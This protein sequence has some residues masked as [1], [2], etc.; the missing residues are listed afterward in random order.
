M[1]TETHGPDL[2]INE[3]TFSLA[4]QWIL[5]IWQQVKIAIQDHMAKYRLDLVAQDIYEF[6][7]NQYCDWYLEFS[8]PILMGKL[9]E[10]KQL[11]GTRYTLLHILGELLRVVHPIMPFITEEIWQKIGPLLSDT[12]K[13]LIAHS[14]PP[15]EK[16][17]INT[18]TENMVEWIKLFITGV[19]NIRGEM[20]IS[21][22]K[23]LPVLLSGADTAEQVKINNHVLFL[24]TLA[25][26]ESISW[27]NA[28][29]QPPPSATA[30]IGNVKLLIPIKGLID[31]NAET[32][33]LKKEMDKITKEL[34][35]TKTKLANPD[36]VKKAPAD[37][38]NKERSRLNEL[39]LAM[40]KLNE[41]LRTIV[42]M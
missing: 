10:P 20:N 39:Q 15:I 23:T 26:L 18:E 19:R 41:S 3:K 36:Y 31:K 37:V 30:L 25:N 5:S 21:P 6:T 29:D 32:T 11:R 27:L 9:S 34:E 22:N 2:Q 24:Q 7:W 33:R 16:Q 28:K 38:V 42:D 4:D 12:N 17:Y 35:R 8:K 14:F 13:T 40:N 1:N